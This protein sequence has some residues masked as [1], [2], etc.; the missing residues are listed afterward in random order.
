MSADIDDFHP[1]DGQLYSVGIHPWHIAGDGS[2][3][4]K[5]LQEAASLP[6]VVGIGECGLDA[7]KGAPM[8]MQ[9]L[10]LQK[11]AEIAHACGKPLILHNVK[12]QQELIGLRQNPTYG[13]DVWI[14]HGFRGKP[15]VAEMLL[16]AGF[17]LSFGPRFNADALRATPPECI[18]AETDDADTDIEHVIAAMQEARPDLP[19]LREIIAQNTAKTLNLNPDK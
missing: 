16:R 6:S 7:A 3:Q 2:E 10:V 8:F 5:K 19:G 11:C 18:L 4:L 13:S 17:M 1:T 9:M 12:M 14:I 15:T